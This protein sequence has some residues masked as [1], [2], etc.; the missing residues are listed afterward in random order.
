M[1]RKLAL[2]L[3]SVSTRSPAEAYAKYL[4]FN[5]TFSESNLTPLG[6]PRLYSSYDGA[7]SLHDSFSRTLGDE[8]VEASSRAGAASAAAATRRFGSY[9]HSELPDAQ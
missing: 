9:D 5:A 7:G 2:T 1:S 8:S 3:C 4:S 6:A